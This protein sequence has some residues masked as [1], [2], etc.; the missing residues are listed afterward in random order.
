MI[1][2]RRR[3]A[4]SYSSFLEAS[5]ISPSSSLIRAATSSGCSCTR[6][7]SP[8]SP[9]RMTRRLSCTGRL[10]LWGVMPWIRLCSI[11]RR[12]RSSVTS[13]RSRMLPVIFSAKRATSP[14]TWRAAR[15][16]V[17]I[18]EVR[19]RRKPSLSASR[20]ATSVTSGRS[21]PS[22]RRLIPTRMSNSPA[23]RDRRI[24]TR[25]IVSMSLWR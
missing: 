20:M 8:S 6:A 18:S 13:R 9:S 22:R 17:W 15:P 16:A 14:F 25:S 2:S 3:A 23:R 4:R 1:W 19:L 10:T 7:E 5:F 21:S 12:R 24:S 11:W